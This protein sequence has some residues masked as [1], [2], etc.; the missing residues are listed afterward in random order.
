MPAR[1]KVF[2]TLNIPWLTYNIQNCRN[3]CKNSVKNWI[4]LQASF[5]SKCLFPGTFAISAAMLYPLPI[6]KNKLSFFTSYL[7]LSHSCQNLDNGKRRKFYW[8]KEMFQYSNS[9]K[10][11][12]SKYF[13]IH[14]FGYE[15]LNIDFQELWGSW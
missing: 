4:F 8:T 14:Y 15:A 9:H 5:Y 13:R 10:I 7:T 11:L 6:W 2:N 12:F 1:L 3:L